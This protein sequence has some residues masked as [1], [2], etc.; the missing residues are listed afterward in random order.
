VRPVLETYCDRLE[1]PQVIEM[2]ARYRAR[3]H[4]TVVGKAV[5]R[6]VSETKL[7]DPSQF[8]IEA[9]CGPPSELAKMDDSAISPPESSPPVGDSGGMIDRVRAEENTR[10]R[11]ALGL[12]GLQ[13]T[14]P[15]VASAS[16]GVMA[17]SQPATY[18]CR[19]ACDFWGPFAQIEPGLGGGKLSLGWGRAM[20]S[21]DPSD[22]VLSRVY[23]ALAGKFTLYRTWSDVGSVASGRTFAGAELEFSIARVNF[24]LGALYQINH[25]DDG[26]LLVTG[27]IGW[28]F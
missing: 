7:E 21:T 17:T 16:L 28:G 15:Q 3:D 5:A 27:G 10:Q 13:L 11:R 14:Y 24:G 19:T 6:L 20:G 25:T 9:V 1:E 2:R 12:I 4:E 26:R 8:A 18:D 23:L 22:T